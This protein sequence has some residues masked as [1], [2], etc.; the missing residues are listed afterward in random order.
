MDKQKY[1][2]C[3]S[4]MLKLSPGYVSRALRDYLAPLE[5]IYGDNFNPIEALDVLIDRAEILIREIE[6]AQS[7]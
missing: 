2:D 6:K 7:K 3:L 4:E 1:L 5:N